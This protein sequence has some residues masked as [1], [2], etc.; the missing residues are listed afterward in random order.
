[1]KLPEPVVVVVVVD[2][3]PPAAVRPLVPA[4][5]VLV[6]VVDAEPERLLQPLAVEHA[7]ARQG[8]TRLRVVD[9]ERLQRRP[10]QVRMARRPQE[11]LLV[12]VVARKLEALLPEARRR[13][14][15]VGVQ[16]AVAAAQA[17]VAAGESR[18][19]QASFA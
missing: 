11:P 18:R 13:A 16:A 7:A 2:A 6:R 15:V 9:V 19:R 1:L 4:P 8:P 17:A 3:E 12:R 5:L 14:A 10:Q